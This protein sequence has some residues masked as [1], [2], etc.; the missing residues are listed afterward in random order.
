MDKDKYLKAGKI[1]NTHGIR[2]EVRIEPWADSPAFLLNID[3]FYIDNEPIKVI[4]SKV[5]KNSLLVSLDGINDFESAIKLKN[6]II[7]ISRHDARLEKGSFF[8]VDL[9]GLNAVNFETGNKIGIVSDYLS[10]PANDVYVIK[11]DDDSG[12]ML[13]PNVPDLVKEINIDT[14]YIK[15]RLIEGF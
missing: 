8:I 9:I 12:E 15:F 5:H 2:G 4:S 10:R 1:L 6:K 7:Y 11:K 13:I 14:G 3:T